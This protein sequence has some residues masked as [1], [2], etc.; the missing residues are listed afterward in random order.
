MAEAQPWRV[1][2]PAHPPSILHGQRRVGKT[3]V[4][5]AL[6]VGL[7]QHGRADCRAADGPHGMQTCLTRDANYA[8]Q[9][10]C[11][12]PEVLAKPLAR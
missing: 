9:R 7:M 11:F 4:A 6:A 2:E 12:V 8:A 3:T 10:A 1:S 5:A